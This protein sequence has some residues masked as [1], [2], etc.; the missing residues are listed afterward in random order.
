MAKAKETISLTDEK[1]EVNESKEE[2]V[3]ETK[4]E[5]DKVPEV[6]ESE[7]PLATEDVLSAKDKAF[8]E[9]IKTVAN[10]KSET[11]ETIVQGEVKKDSSLTGVGI[12]EGY[13][14]TTSKEGYVDLILPELLGDVIGSKFTIMLNGVHYT[15]IVDGITPNSVPVA[16]A[17]WFN[18]EKLPKINKHHRAENRQDVKDM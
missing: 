13:I 18:K 7:K 17:E 10:S 5:E 9:A 14:E 12:Q 2:K 1:P 8:I 4:V 3:V 16:F 11:K 6:K 15:L